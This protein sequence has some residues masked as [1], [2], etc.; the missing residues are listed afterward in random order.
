MEVLPTFQVTSEVT[1]VWVLTP[2][3]VAWA[4]NVIACP[5]LTDVGEP[6]M[7]KVFTTGHTL[8]VELEVLLMA[9]TSAET[10]VVPGGFGMLARL[11]AVI[12][13]ITLLLNAAT[14]GLEEVH[15]ALL[16]TSLVLPSL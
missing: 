1:S 14:V 15:D 11:V 4:V 10:V 7:V 8:T 16:V 12:W 2:W 3:K 13:P 5:V 6:E 9:P